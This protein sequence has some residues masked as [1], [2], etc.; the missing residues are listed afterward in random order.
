MRK[1]IIVLKSK[2]SIL[3]LDSLDNL[4][5][6]FH[7]FVLSISMKNFLSQPPEMLSFYHIAPQIIN[8]LILL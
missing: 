5:G 1:I 8:I 3:K 7:Y 2:Y 4:D 6:Y